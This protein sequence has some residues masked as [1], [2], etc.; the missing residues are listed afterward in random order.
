MIRGLQMV[1]VGP[2][3]REATRKFQSDIGFV[4]DGY[5]GYELFQQ[6]Q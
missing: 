2:K 5:V 6:L 3:T 1:W 4:A